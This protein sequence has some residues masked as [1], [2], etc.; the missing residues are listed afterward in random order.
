VTGPTIKAYA[1]EPINPEG[2]QEPSIGKE[3]HKIKKM[4]PEAQAILK[5]LS[6]IKEPGAFVNAAVSPSQVATRHFIMPAVPKNEEAGAVR[7]EASRYI[8]FKISDSVTDYYAQRTHRNVLSVTASAIRTEVLETCLEDLRAASAKVLMVEPAYSSVSRV[9]AAL[10]VAGKP[11]SQGFLILESDGNV[12]VTMV[13]KGVVYLSREFFLTGKPEEDKVKFCEE[14]K[15]SLD[16]FYKL[17]GGEAIEQIFLA[18]AGDL[19]AWIEHLEHAFNYT[20]R[21]DSAKSPGVKNVPQETLGVLLVAFGLALRSLGYHSP[22]G[23]IKLLPREERRSET[24][25]LLTFLGIECLAIVLLFAVVRLAVFQPYL[26]YLEGRSEAILGDADRENP[27]FVSKSLEDLVT[28]KEKLK[29]RTA[30]LKGFFGDQYP[31]SSFLTS[32]G[33]GLPK[34]IVLDYISLENAGEKGKT[35]SGKEK[36]R[37]NM[38]GICF[39]GNAEKETAVISSWVKSLSEKQVMA[40]YFGEMKLEEIKREKLQNRNL[41]RF[42]IIAE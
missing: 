28:E 7:H 22:L 2:P 8:P 21:F 37:L 11:K 29:E 18:G 10:N 41:T 36:K 14:L 25:K 32:L 19:K 27:Q 38:R 40:D 16:Y 17:T 4:S 13:S 42:R 3:A 5:A 26:M 30:Q 15:A 34:S 12:N 35:S 31:A 23:D 24:Q 6:K 1:I 9:F 39:L 33:Q 20:I